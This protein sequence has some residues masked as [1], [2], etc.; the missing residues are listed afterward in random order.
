MYKDPIV[1]RKYMDELIIDIINWI[2]A[3]PENSVTCCSWAYEWNNLSDTTNL[4]SHFE[5][6]C[7]SRYIHFNKINHPMMAIIKGEYN[8]KA[9][10]F[11]VTSTLNNLWVIPDQN[12]KNICIM[13][14]DRIKTIQIY[15]IEKLYNYLDSFVGTETRN[16][17]DLI[18]DN[19]FLNIPRLLTLQKVL[20]DMN[21]NMKNVLANDIIIEI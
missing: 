17:V 13:N 21:P 20:N 11:C 9:V 2:N 10:F 18:P 6:N 5:K 8:L 19:Y 7:K 4:H 1:T 16:N 12:D 3:D 14:L 15:D